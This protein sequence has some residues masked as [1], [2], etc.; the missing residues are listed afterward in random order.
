LWTSGVGGAASFSTGQLSGQQKYEKYFNIVLTGS[1]HINAEP[2]P[3]ESK[4]SRTTRGCFCGAFFFASL[5][6]CPGITPD[7]VPALGNSGQLKRP[8]KT[9]SGAG[10]RRWLARA[11]KKGA[12]LRPFQGNRTPGLG[13]LPLLPFGPDGVRGEPAVR[14]PR[15]KK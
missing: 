10:S 5:L 2:P 11:T 15:C 4:A 14:L 13:P 9:C 8:Q 12:L 3:N 7:V 1:C 6:I